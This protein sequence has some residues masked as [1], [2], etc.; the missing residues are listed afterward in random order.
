MLAPVYYVGYIL[1]NPFKPIIVA[2][3]KILTAFLF[4]DVT[5]QGHCSNLTCTHTNRHLHLLTYTVSHNYV[6]CELV[7]CCFLGIGHV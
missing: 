7:F 1:L 3:Q 4:C 6:P 2:Y 5:K